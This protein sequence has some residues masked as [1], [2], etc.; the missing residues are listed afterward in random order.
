MINVV[1]PS[2]SIGSCT[3]S[4]SICIEK[5]YIG[6]EYGKRDETSFGNYIEGVN[7]LH[8]RSMLHIIRSYGYEDMEI[9]ERTTF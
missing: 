6:L 9:L 4:E 5:L 8:K 2:D 1:G 3:G 7:V